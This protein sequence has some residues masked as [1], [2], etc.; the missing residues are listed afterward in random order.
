M[1]VV[2]DVVLHRDRDAVQRPAQP[3]CRALAVEFIGE[4]E[5]ACVHGQRRVDAVFV[6]RDAREV[7]RHQLAR[8]DAPVA[9]RR[10]QVPETRLDHRERA[11]RGHVRHALLHDQRTRLVVAPGRIEEARLLAADE[12]VAVALAGVAHHRLAAVEHLALVGGEDRLLPVPRIAE[13]DRGEAIGV[14]GLC[15][16]REVRRA[17]AAD[18]RIRPAVLDGVVA[19]PRAD[20]VLLD[21]VHA[22]VG[23]AAV[24]RDQLDLLRA[25]PA[26]R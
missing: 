10:L 6:L 25:T 20:E 15:A 8:G 9:Q 4:F 16:T 23:R 14:R 24:A 26:H 2:W 19:A 12:P 13:L 5:R 21:A 22:P 7:L 18:G 3:A 17:E 11:R 1:S